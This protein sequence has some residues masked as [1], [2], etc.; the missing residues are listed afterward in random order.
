MSVNYFGSDQNMY[1][2]LINRCWQTVYVHSFTCTR[3]LSQLWDDKWNIRPISYHHP[4]QWSVFMY[5]HSWFSL[6]WPRGHSDPSTNIS[7]LFHIR[8]KHILLMFA[9]MFQ[10]MFV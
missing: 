2:I 3:L 7:P 10:A 1:I 9:C 4:L 8:V 5:P 6:P